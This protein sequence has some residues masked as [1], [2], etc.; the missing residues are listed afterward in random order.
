MVKM[1]I[2]CNFFVD[3]VGVVNWLMMRLGNVVF[4]L[5]D[6]R[7]REDCIIG[8]YY[9]FIFEQNKERVILLF[10][11]SGLKRIV[12]VIIVFSMGVNFFDVRFVLMFGS[13]RSIF[14]FY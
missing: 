5:Q 12:I 11:G 6:F 8:I 10:K 4:Y 3:I 2:F 9:L 13:L 14:D 7:K 1:I